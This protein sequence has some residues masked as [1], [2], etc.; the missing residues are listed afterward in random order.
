MTSFVKAIH[1]HGDSI[2]DRDGF[3]LV[4]R[5]V[6]SRGFVLR[7]NVEVK[8]RKETRERPQTKAPKGKQ[9]LAIIGSHASGSF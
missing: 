9:T 4:C 1:L 7:E 6:M 8:R 5:F 2:F 3:V